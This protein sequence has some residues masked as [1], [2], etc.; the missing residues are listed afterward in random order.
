MNVITDFQIFLECLAAFFYLFFC[1]LLCTG[2]QMLW[3]LNIL[4][5]KRE[6]QPNSKR[7]ETYLTV[8]SQCYPG[9]ND[10]LLREVAGERS[11]LGRRISSLWGVSGA[12][13]I[14]HINYL[15]TMRRCL[16]VSG[17]LTACV[18]SSVIRGTQWGT[19]ILLNGAS[20]ICVARLCY[21]NFDKISICRTVSLQ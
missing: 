3:A 1:H 20:L 21:Y 4:E 7:R 6:W 11:V 17:N 13:A 2:K 14:L 12:Q 16:L 5:L 9:Q 10:F 15:Y 19:A 8:Y 18:L